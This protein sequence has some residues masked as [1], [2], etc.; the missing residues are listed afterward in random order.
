[1]FSGIYGQTAQDGRSGTPASHYPG[2]DYNNTNPYLWLNAAASNPAAAA[3]L[4]SNPY[5]A[6]YMQAAS[7]YGP[8]FG[9]DLSSL[10]TIP[11]QAELFKLVR[12]P[13]S[14]SALIAMAI[15]NAPDKKL[16]LSQIYQ[17]VAENFPF[18]KKSRA[19]WQNSIRHNLSLNDCFKKVPRDEDDPGKGNYWTLDP[20]CEKMFDNGNF[21]RK[22]KRR[23]ANGKLDYDRPPDYNLPHVPHPPGNVATSPTGAVEGSTEQPASHQ[24]PSSV[25]EAA[26]QQHQAIAST[27]SDVPST[28]HLT[29]AHTS[30][31]QEQTLAPPLPAQSPLPPQGSIAAAVKTEL[32]MSL[33]TEIDARPPPVPDQSQLGISWGDQATPAPPPVSDQPPVPTSTISYNPDYNGGAFT[34]NFSVNNMIHKAQEGAAEYKL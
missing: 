24:P 19:G 3:S 18:Y 31:I 29:P 14:Y 7:Q 32:N 20:N 25:A 9:G 8:G 17:Y 33:K 5:A 13:Y 23:D 11:N 16:T 2:L 1:M 27:S 15:Q 22:R 34:Y 12:P 10:W 6:S 30:V 4:G 26:T 28:T 21:R